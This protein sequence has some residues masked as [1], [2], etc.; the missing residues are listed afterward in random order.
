MPIEIG[1]LTE[2][3]YFEVQSDGLVGPL[4]S[5]LGNRRELR[6]LWLGHNKG[7]EGS[8]NVLQSNPLLGTIFVKDNQFSGS[9]DLFPLL[10]KLEWFDGSHNSLEGPLLEEIAGLKQLR[11]SFVLFRSIV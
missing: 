8:L 2:I 6:A 1:L 4:P 5:S 7:L 3:R 11:R 9:L 10:S